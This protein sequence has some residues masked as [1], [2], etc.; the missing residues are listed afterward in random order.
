M[1]GESFFP[2]V[3]VDSDEVEDD[4]EWCSCNSFGME[5]W[6]RFSSPGSSPAV[7]C[8]IRCSLF[9]IGICFVWSL[10]SI[11]LIV[12]F[13]TA[14]C[15]KPGGGRKAEGSGSAEKLAISVCKSDLCKS[16]ARVAFVPN[17]GGW[18]CSGRV[19]CTIAVDGEPI[20]LCLVASSSAF[21]AQ[22]LLGNK[23]F[24]V[25]NGLHN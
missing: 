10:D 18:R 17:R 9:E 21:D 2:Q 1:E 11:G 6:E 16:D 12:C 13:D 7:T 3:D 25:G 19:G 14:F 8:F 4:M 24:L 15:R 5:Y 23:A 22:G 20:T